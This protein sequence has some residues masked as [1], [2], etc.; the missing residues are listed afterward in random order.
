VNR[1]V[2]ACALMLSTLTASAAPGEDVVDVLCESHFTADTRPIVIR[3]LFV[4]FPLRL[5]SVQIE[6]DAPFF[7]SSVRVNAHEASG[8]SGKEGEVQVL[9]RLDRHT[10]RL[11][12][13]ANFNGSNTIIEGQCN[14]AERR[15]F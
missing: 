7:L 3:V 11:V 1:F 14:T 9:Y 8:L 13:R 2:F 15:K 6:R 10:G 12:V 5:M 4:E